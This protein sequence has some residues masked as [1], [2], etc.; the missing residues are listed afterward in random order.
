[1]ISDSFLKEHKVKNVNSKSW[2]GGITLSVI[3]E[4]NRIFEKTMIDVDFYNLDQIAICM[5]LDNSIIV[6]RQKKINKIKNRV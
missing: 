2:N 6:Q 4:D 1:M 3:F 5:I